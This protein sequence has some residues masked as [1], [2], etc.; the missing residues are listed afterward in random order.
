MISF[1]RIPRLLCYKNA[2]IQ[3]LTN[4]SPEKFVFYLHEYS[5][6]RYFNYILSKYFSSIERVG[7]QHG[8]ASKRKLLYYIGNNM[9]SNINEDW[10]LKNSYSK[11]S[12]EIKLTAN[13]RIGI[14][15]SYYKSK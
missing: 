5:Y 14:Y 6:G 9:V 2:I 10:L 13:E 8:P 1:S 3:S 11:D 15:A 12:M 7:F 4:H